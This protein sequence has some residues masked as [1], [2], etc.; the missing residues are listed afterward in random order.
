MMEGVR[1]PGARDVLKHLLS[2]MLEA[3]SIV[4]ESSGSTDSLMLLDTL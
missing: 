4:P 2:C 1:E 3:Y